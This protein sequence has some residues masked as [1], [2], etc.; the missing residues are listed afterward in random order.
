MACPLDSGFGVGGGVDVVKPF[1]HD[2]RVGAVVHRFNHHDV[3]AG[4]LEVGGGGR[5]GG[6]GWRVVGGSRVHESDSGTDQP[7]V[8]MGTR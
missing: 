4:D 7:P 6:G 5:G 3:L 2:L 1:Q 8:S